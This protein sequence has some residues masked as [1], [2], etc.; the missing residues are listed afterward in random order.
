MERE[1]PGEGSGE[2]HRGGSCRNTHG[3]SGSGRRGSS[4]CSAKRQTADQPHFDPSDVKL[5]AARNR[6]PISQPTACSSTKYC[7]FND[8]PTTVPSK[9][10][11][12]NLHR[13]CLT[14]KTC[15]HILSGRLTAGKMAAPKM[16]KNQMRRAKKKEQ[17]KAQVDGDVSNSLLVLVVDSS[18]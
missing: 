5:L 7:I 11:L 3:H 14:P 17:R 1:G 8:S 9:S 10:N 18:C 4:S 12:D 13:G 16:T 15:I 6:R 2:E